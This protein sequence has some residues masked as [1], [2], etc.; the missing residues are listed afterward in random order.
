[1]GRPDNAPFSIIT[2]ALADV[3]QPIRVRWIGTGCLPS[4]SWVCNPEH[5]PTDHH[6]SSHHQLTEQLL[7]VYHP[8]PYSRHQLIHNSLPNTQFQL[9]LLL[10]QLKHLQHPLNSQKFH[11]LPLSH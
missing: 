6:H 11:L 3:P 9:H 1:M 5:Q 8:L 2:T 7:T 10:I 4:L